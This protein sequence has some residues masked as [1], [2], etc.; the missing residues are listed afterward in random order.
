MA[1]AWAYSG[2]DRLQGKSSGAEG[3]GEES[4]T[5]QPFTRA[6]VFG[7]TPTA[8]SKVQS[9][10]VASSGICASLNAH[11]RMSACQTA[12]DNF[13]SLLS[14]PTSE[15]PLRNVNIT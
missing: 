9:F 14:E 2:A 13:N 1:D 11:R 4:T 15:P 10:S 8:A 6:R 7:K 5:T 3:K 12:V